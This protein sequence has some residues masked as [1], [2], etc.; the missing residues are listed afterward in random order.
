MQLNIV[1]PE[2]G[3]GTLNH[4]C[5]SHRAT[6]TETYFISSF[7]KIAKCLKKEKQ[8]RSSIDT[9]RLALNSITGNEVTITGIPGDSKWSPEDGLQLP[10]TGGEGQHEE[11]AAGGL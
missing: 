6:E 4:I 2:K 7:N 1:Q 5:H 10:G 9:L 3:S 11:T 8:H